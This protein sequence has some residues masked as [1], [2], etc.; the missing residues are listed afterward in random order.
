M[1]TGG[2]VL[3]N[4]S[5]FA[6]LSHLCTL[7]SVPLYESVAGQTGDLE[8]S[9]WEPTPAVSG[10]PETSSRCFHKDSVPVLFP[11][12]AN[13]EVGIVCNYMGWA[14]KT[15]H[16]VSI[17]LRMTPQQDT[18]GEVRRKA[19]M[20]SEKVSNTLKGPTCTHTMWSKPAAHHVIR[21]LLNKCQARQ[22]LSQRLGAQ[23]DPSHCI[24]HPG[25]QGSHAQNRCSSHDSW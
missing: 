21:Q 24:Q 5:L 13:R 3:V 25:H 23:T 16:L 19:D 18:L 22:V 15:R 7:Y 12:D 14:E 6:S 8:A 10:K 17:I 2:F 4:N 11:T 20:D 9:V 1:V